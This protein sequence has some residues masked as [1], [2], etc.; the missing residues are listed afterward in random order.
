MK[1]IALIGSTGSIGTQ[2]LSVISKHPD[3]F[4]VI[5]ISAGENKD[6]FLKQVKDF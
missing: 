1:K 2:V 3:N 4:K 5:S 6:L